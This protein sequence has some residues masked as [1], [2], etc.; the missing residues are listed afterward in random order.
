MIGNKFDLR[1]KQNK[2]NTEEREAMGGV[3]VV[4]SAITLFQMYSL[5]M[6]KRPVKHENKHIAHQNQFKTQMRNL[7]PSLILRCTSL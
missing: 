7:Q 2:N 4:K 5:K 6:N 1:C 3:V